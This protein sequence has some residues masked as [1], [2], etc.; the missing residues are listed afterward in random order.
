M[1]KIALV[2]IGIFLSGPFPGTNTSSEDLCLA[3]SDAEK[4]LGSA[5]KQT[6]SE[7]LNNKGVVVHKCTWRASNE[8]LNSNLYYV[9]EQYDNAEAA[10]KVFADIVTSNT[11][12]GQSRPNIGDEAWFHSDD[13][14]FCIIIVRKGNKM[15]RMKV[16]KLTKETSVNEMK[17]VASA[18][19]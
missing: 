14:N 1:E 7:T 2:L 11:G 16:S 5:A 17:R 15:I 10:H 12:T 19:E 13:T 4:I 8:T 18:W 9:G 6:E 3:K